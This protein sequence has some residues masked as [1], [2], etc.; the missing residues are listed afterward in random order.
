LPGQGQG[1]AALAG[2]F[3]LPCLLKAYLAGTGKA[4]NMDADFLWLKR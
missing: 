4:D 3:L 2:Y 1:E